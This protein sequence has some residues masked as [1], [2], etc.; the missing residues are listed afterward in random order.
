[1][2]YS[3]SLLRIL[4]TKYFPSVIPAHYMREIFSQRHCDEPEA[5]KQSR[6]SNAV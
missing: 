2:L 4:R 6:F 3:A 1:M 5:K